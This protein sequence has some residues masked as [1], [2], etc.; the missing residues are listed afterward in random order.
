MLPGTT[1]IFWRDLLLGKGFEKPFYH[2]APRGYFVFRKYPFEV[3]VYDGDLQLKRFP[4]LFFLSLNTGK[5]LALVSGGA[6][7]L[8][9]IKTVIEALVN[10]D[11]VPLC[12]GIPWAEPL[13][14]AL[15]KRS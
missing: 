13:V 5:T 15:C 1:Y 3:S 6:K 11:Y 2:R 14:E 4:S 12:I 7:E 9:N 8:E 10:P